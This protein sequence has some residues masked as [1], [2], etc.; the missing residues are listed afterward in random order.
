MFVPPSPSGRRAGDEGLDDVL[1][2]ETFSQRTFHLVESPLGIITVRV[3]S[4]KPSPCPLP[5]GEGKLKIHAN[6]ESKNEV[7]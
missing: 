7:N 3:K 1:K 4:R 2:N 6:Q 5:M